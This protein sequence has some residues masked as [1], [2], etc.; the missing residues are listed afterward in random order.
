[1]FVNLFN[2]GIIAAATLGSAY[3]CYFFLSF[4]WRA[5]RTGHLPKW[6]YRSTQPKSY[7]ARLFW[8]SVLGVGCGCAAVYY[9]FWAIPFHWARLAN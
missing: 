9:G 1:M 2:F 6:N 8:L 7:W 5:L 3:G 4:V